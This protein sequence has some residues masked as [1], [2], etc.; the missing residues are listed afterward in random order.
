VKP[1]AQHGGSQTFNIINGGVIL[2]V[3][4]SSQK[5][6]I[7]I[8]DGAANAKAR[9][10]LPNADVREQV[11]LTWARLDRDEAKTKGISSPDKGIIE[12]IDQK[13]KAILFTES[14]API[15]SMMIA[16]KDNPMQTVYFV[17]VQIVL[18]ADKIVAYRVIGFHGKEEL[19]SASN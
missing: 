17:D 9:L 4:T 14:M 2:N 18:V 19:E 7:E 12:E 10:L 5:D 13:P 15:K 1:I 11:A 16:D 8:I 3:L 6:A